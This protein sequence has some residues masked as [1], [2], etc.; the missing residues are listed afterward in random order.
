MTWGCC[1]GHMEKV[2]EVSSRVLGIQEIFEKCQVAFISSQF[3]SG[4]T[5]YTNSLEV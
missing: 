5:E 1:V 4:R 2:C 3:A